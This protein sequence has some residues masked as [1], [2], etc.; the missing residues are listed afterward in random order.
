MIELKFKQGDLT[1]DEQQIVTSGFVRH[2][3][4]KSAP[5]YV[6]DRLNWLAYHQ[7]S[8]LVGVLTADRLWDWLYIDELWVDETCRGTG[9]GKKLMAQAET[10]VS[11]HQLSGVW[12]WTQSWQAA[13]FYKALG[14]Q[15]F[16]RF[17]DF[18][19]GYSRIG[20]RKELRAPV[21]S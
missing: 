12:L 16:A 20:F 10:Y 1:Q 5:A 2:A 13:D 14:Y 3:A 15:E 7:N 18:P 8:G 17:K 9:L 21:G 6:K 19:K 11:A 4:N